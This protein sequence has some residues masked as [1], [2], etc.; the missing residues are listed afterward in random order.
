[1]LRIVA[2]EDSA[3]DVHRE[4]HVR[5]LNQRQFGGTRAGRA[6][7]HKHVEVVSKCGV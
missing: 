6:F 2:I 5:P 3:F 1:M 7:H 4:A